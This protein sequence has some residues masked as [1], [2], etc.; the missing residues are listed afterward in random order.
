MDMTSLPSSLSLRLKTTPNMSR[1]VP[2][3]QSARLV[4]RAAEKNDVDKAF[5]H[6]IINDPTVSAFMR[7]S[8]H[9]PQTMDDAET[10]IKDMQNAILGV[11]ICLPVDPTPEQSSTSEKLAATTTPIGYL[12]LGL[13]DLDSTGIYWGQHRECELGLALTP[14]YHGKGY[15][16]EALNWSVDW[17]FRRANLHIVT[18]YCYGYNESAHGLY[19]KAGFTLDARLRHRLWFDGNWHDMLHFSILDTEWKALRDSE[20]PS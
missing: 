3:F 9:K 17:A 14:A 5:I 6:G 19:E 8:V 4:Y 10:L 20:K 12:F 11:I 16:R 7:A 1:A 13:G 2:T 18:L 15:G